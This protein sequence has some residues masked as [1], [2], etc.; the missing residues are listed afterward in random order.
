MNL[1]LSKRVRSNHACS[2]Q[3]LRRFK[4]VCDLLASVLVS[5][6]GLPEPPLPLTLSLGSNQFDSEKSCGQK[7]ERRNI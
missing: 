5:Q 1:C 2:G 7:K 4:T 3:R 6:A